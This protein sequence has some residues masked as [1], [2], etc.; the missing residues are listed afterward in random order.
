MSLKEVAM[1]VFVAS[2]FV[3]SD[4]L[5]VWL[6]CSCFS[7][8]T[9]EMTEQEWHCPFGLGKISRFLAQNVKPA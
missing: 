5:L 7:V 8:L 9:K 1:V 6:L 3:G 2:M 4:R